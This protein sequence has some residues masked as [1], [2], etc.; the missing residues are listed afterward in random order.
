MDRNLAAASLAVILVSVTSVAQAASIEIT[1]GEVL[2]NR[3]A[4]YQSIRNSTDLQAGD[5]V[6]SKMGSAAKITFADGC[7]VPLRTGMIFT[8]EAQSPCASAGASA[9]QQSAQQLSDTDRT[10]NLAGNDWDA[11][12]QTFPAA[13]EVQSNV[14]PYF[15]GAAAVGGIAAAVSG[16]GGGGGASPISP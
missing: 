2:L 5:I 1:Q 3:G 14:W 13:D 7:T 10:L 6:V 16:L 8:V 15:L 11:G 9:H 12:T 4:G